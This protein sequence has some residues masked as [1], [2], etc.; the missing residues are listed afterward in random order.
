MHGM[1]GS[2]VLGF[3]FV[4]LSKSRRKLEVWGVAL[5]KWRIIVGLSVVIP[6]DDLI[7][8]ECVLECVR[9]SCWWHIDCRSPV[10]ALKSSQWKQYWLL[11]E[12]CY[13]DICRKQLLHLVEG[14]L[15]WMNPMQHVACDWHLSALTI[16][17]STARHTGN[18]CAPLQDLESIFLELYF[19]RKLCTSQQ[20]KA[21]SWLTAWRNRTLCQA[22][23]WT[24]YCNSQPLFCSMNLFQL[25]SMVTNWSWKLVYLFLQGL[26]PLAGSNNESWC[27]GLDGLASRTAAY[28]KQGARFDKW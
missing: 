5:Y 14:F 3:V 8:E 13:G 27:Q 22:S 1:Y 12:F 23:R 16:R 28:Y 2:R 24:R 6:F 10:I 11:D 15:P 19:L 9:P 25:A 26:V 7:S 17:K 4:R 18:Y 21:S 20:V